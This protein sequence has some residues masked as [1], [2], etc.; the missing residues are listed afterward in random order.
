MAFAVVVAIA[1]SVTLA[2]GSSGGSPGVPAL[3]VRVPRVNVPNLI[4]G[5]PA[6][7]TAA[8]DGRAVVLNFWGSW[9]PPCQ[10]E[11]PT[12]QAAHQK[13]GD[14][15]TFIGVDEHDGRAAALRFL[16]SVGVTYTVGFDGNARVASTF[17][18]TAFPTTY[19]ISRGRELDFVPGKLT[20][21]TL[22]E[23]L[24]QWFA[25]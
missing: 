19:F 5:A 8:L 1:L 24:R 20:E 11:M 17:E 18:V 6:I 14:R 21:T 22:R 7:S 12:L 3:N 4:S 15:V 16:H 9:C 25:V 23:N 13:L 10:E 2:L